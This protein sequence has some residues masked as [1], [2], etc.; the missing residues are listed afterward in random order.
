MRQLKIVTPDQ[1]VFHLTAA[2]LSTR[3]AAWAL[4]QIILM[5]ARIGLLLAMAWVDMFLVQFIIPLLIILDT[6]YFV[7]LE[8]R[9]GG[10]TFGKQRLGI[11]V[12]AVNGARLTFQDVLIRNVIR[13][14]DNLVPFMLVGG[15]ASFSDS[16]GRR[17]GDLAAGTM[18]IRDKTAA[19]M[20]PQADRD[21]PNSY[22]DDPGCR[23]RIQ[24]RATKE[25]RDLAIELMWRRD[26]L[27]PEA[28][29]MLFA[30]LSGEFRRR[31]NLPEDDNLSNEQSVMDVALLLAERD[32][33]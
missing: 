12:V 32:D 21:R 8:W 15:V 26:E 20:P 31:F 4:D 10:Q 24:A 6:L 7:F 33:G 27:Q 28:R 2:G 13:I 5:A 14:V 17:L 18:V 22:R 3:A 11:R 9:M 23:R 16:L 25:D 29:E 1:V 30:R 19:F